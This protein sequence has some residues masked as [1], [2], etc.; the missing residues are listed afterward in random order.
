M[1]QEASG[2]HKQNGKAH[3]AGLEPGF[4]GLRR[5]QW[6]L[7][8]RDS[9]QDRRERREERRQASVSLVFDDKILPVP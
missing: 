5:E 9:I 6:R 1:V 2:D 8:G 3:L 7:T 4:S